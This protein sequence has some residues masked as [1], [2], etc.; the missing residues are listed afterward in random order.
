MGFR[1]AAMTR[2]LS[3]KGLCSS[4]LGCVSEYPRILWSSPE[5]SPVLEKCWR[6][7]PTL[8]TVPNNQRHVPV[9]S[10]PRRSEPVQQV[11]VAKSPSGGEGDG[12]AVWRDVDVS[13]RDEACEVVRGK[14]S[15]LDDSAAWNVIAQKVR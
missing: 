15:F 6:R 9:A 11:E 13:N 2:R 10:A 12:T 8:Q 14:G 5:F 4:A 7:K 1:K 3:S